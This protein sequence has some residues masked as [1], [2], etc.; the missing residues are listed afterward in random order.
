MKYKIILK[1]SG[2]QVGRCMLKTET[3]KGR[4]REAYTGAKM[5]LRASFGKR[6]L[7]ILNGKESLVD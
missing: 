7:A 1:D 5:E 2:W 4:V 6:E 3:E